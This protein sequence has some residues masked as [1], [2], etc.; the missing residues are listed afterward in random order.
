MNPEEMGDAADVGS[1][2]SGILLARFAHD[3]LLADAC[4]NWPL[5]C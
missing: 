4:D 5:A 2:H 1:G 3:R